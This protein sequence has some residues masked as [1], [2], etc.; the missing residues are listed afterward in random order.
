VPAVVGPHVLKV[1]LK[2]ATKGGGAAFWNTVRARQFHRSRRI[3]FPLKHDGQWHEHALELPIKARLVGLRLDPGAAPGLV[4]IDWI[5][6][7]R[8]DGT[9]AKAWE[10]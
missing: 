6:L 3:D 5:R 9:V 8:P 2:C 10:F 7:C 4:E 1:R